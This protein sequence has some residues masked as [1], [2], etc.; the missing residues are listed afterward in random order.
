MFLDKENELADG[1][2]VTASAISENVIDL[3]A[4]N[5]DPANGEPLFLVLQVDTAAAAAGAATVDV[6]IESDSTADLATSPTVHVATDPIAKA[7]LVAGYTKIIPIPP[8][9]YERYLGV[10]FTVA[11]GPLTAGNFSA[12]ITHDVQNWKSHADAI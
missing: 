6:T 8:G 1:Q 11:T 5:N 2:A 7:T 9:D 3:G 12:F 10:R 4:A